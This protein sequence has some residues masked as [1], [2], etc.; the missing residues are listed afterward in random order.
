MRKELTQKLFSDYPKLYVDKDKPDHVSLMCYGFECGDG[1]FD[2]I[3]DLSASLEKFIEEKNI[4]LRAMQVKQ[5]FGGL[6]FYTEQNNVSKEDMIVA[7]SFIKKAEELSYKTCETC[8]KP[9]VIRND[10]DSGWVV[11][12]CD[13][14]AKK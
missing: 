6:R 11:A 3:N 12:L 2:L 9:G 13:E 5:K 7:Y 1:W 8:G 14:H 4:N 10:R